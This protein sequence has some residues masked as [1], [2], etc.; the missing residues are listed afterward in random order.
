M[1]SLPLTV[2]VPGTGSVVLILPQPPTLDALHRIEQAVADTLGTLRRDL[3]DGACE[4]G[5]RE[6]GAIEY[7]SWMPDAGAIEYAS[8]TACLQPARR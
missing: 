8:W 7:A 1:T 5:A 6:A 3:R 4:A 2:P